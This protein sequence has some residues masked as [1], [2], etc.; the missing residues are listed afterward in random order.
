MLDI[1]H[2][3]ARVTSPGQ[4]E[5]RTIRVTVDSL[6]WAN[7]L[8]EKGLARKTSTRC[9]SDGLLAVLDLFDETNVARM[10]TLGTWIKQADDCIT[11]S[12][13]FSLESGV[14]QR[15]EALAEFHGVTVTQVARALS[16]VAVK[17]VH[18]ELIGQ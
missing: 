2:L 1:Q 13:T 7:T 4:S 9:L 16:H 3:C 18:N 15:V 17:Q 14:W 12:Q 6:R 11:T 8:R 10:N 5:K